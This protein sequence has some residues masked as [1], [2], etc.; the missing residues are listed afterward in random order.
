MS[1]DVKV[2]DADSSIQQL[3]AYAGQPHLPTSLCFTV[4]WLKT[5]GPAFRTIDRLHV[6]VALLLVICLSHQPATAQMPAVVEGHIRVATFN[7]SLNRKASGEL[8]SDLAAGDDQATNIAIILRTVR[9]DI[10]LL[11][12]FDYDDSGESILAFRANYLELPALA[13]NISE[14]INYPHVF[15]A[16]VN[17][18]VPSGLDLNQN[19]VTT[20]SADAFGFGDFPGQYGMVVL[21][22]YPIQ[23]DAVRTFQKLLWNSMP[24]AAAPTDPNTGE[25]WYPVEIWSKLRLSSKS[26]WDVPVQVGDNV[27][28]VLASHPTPPAFDGPEDRN[29]RRNHDE[30]RFWSDYL[31]DDGNDWIV[32]DRGGVGGLNKE[33]DFVIVGDLNADPVDGG[34]HRQAIRQLLESERVN[35]AVVPASA[36]GSQAA[37]RQGKANSRQSGTPAYDTADFSDRSVGNLRVDYVLPADNLSVRRSAVFWPK[38]GQ[39]LYAATQNSDHHLVWVDVRLPME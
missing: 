35:A 20:D 29:G 14:P 22:R 37:K 38:I 9:P 34:S 26:H 13:G 5:L 17:T 23:T 39:P 6:I 15:T 30:I 25:A 31:L 36:G 11:N 16:P 4:H 7:V 28:H 18:G 19:G 2:N 3:E 12:E 32:D 33:A 21:S 27:L 24:D 1:S 8:K 10:V